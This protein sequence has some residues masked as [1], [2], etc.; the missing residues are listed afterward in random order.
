MLDCVSL[1]MWVW[2]ELNDKI[3]Q[4]VPQATHESTYHWCAHEC[5]PSCFTLIFQNPDLQDTIWKCSHWT[6]AYEFRMQLDS[7]LLWIW[8]PDMDQGV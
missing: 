4:P 3:R 6:E 5:F 7:D 2:V 1:V 8:G